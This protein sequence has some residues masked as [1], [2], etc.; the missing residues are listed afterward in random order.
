MD[1]EFRRPVMCGTTYRASGSY[2][3]VKHGSYQVSASIE[4]GSG[5]VCAKAVGL[6]RKAKDMPSEELFRNLDFS[7][8]S[9][10]ME[11]FLRATIKENP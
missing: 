3:G 8:S 1:I 11:S 2:H 9:E 6:F 7:E 5:K 10:Y 4:D